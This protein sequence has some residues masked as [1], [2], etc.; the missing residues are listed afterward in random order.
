MVQIQIK[1]LNI[2]EYK[3]CNVANFVIPVREILLYYFAKG[4]SH[5]FMVDPCHSGP[6]GEPDGQPKT[7]NECLTLCQANAMCKGV[8]YKP[9]NN[10]YVYHLYRPDSVAKR[11][12]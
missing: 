4:C 8:N 5:E 3:V 1:I 7:V 9:A 2:W 10:T 11:R 6:H 12:T